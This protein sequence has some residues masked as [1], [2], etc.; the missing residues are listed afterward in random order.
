MRFKGIRVDNTLELAKRLDVIK[1]TLAEMIE[2]GGFPDVVLHPE[3]RAEL[4][5]SYFDTIVVKDVV[6]RYGLR[7]EEKVRTL[8]KFYISSSAS[9]VTYNSVSKFLKIPVKT[10]ERYSE[11]LEKSYLIFFLKN[12]SVSPKAVENSPRKVYVIDNGFL[13]YFSTAS[14]GRA[15][16]T[17]VVQHLHKYALDKFYEIY[18][19][20]SGDSEVDV[21][22]KNGRKIVPIQ[23]TYEL[24][25]NKER[26]VKGV[27][28]FRKYAT[29]DTALILTFGQEGEIEGVKVLPAY[30]FLLSLENILDPLTQ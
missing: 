19:W 10:V 1:G 15:F 3:V 27:K 21:V 4:I 20:S 12:Y 26:E 18:Y 28:V 2:Y 8:A 6:N 17:L 25:E 24:N 11:Y 5:H 30:K 29:F 9:K 7:S 16:E 23:V 22:I 13:K 14:L